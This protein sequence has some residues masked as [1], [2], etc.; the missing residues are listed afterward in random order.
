M[1]NMIETILQ[2]ISPEAR[3]ALAAYFGETPDS[4]D[5]ALVSIIPTLLAAMVSRSEHG[6]LES[7][8]ALVRTSLEHD[9]ALDDLSAALSDPGRRSR[10]LA[11]GG[12]FVSALLGGQLGPVSAALTGRSGV[13]GDTI[14]GLLQLGG[15]LVTGGVGKML[16]HHQPTSQELSTLLKSERADIFARLPSGISSLLAPLSGAATPATAA[17][18]REEIFGP[19]V[20]LQPA[21]DADEAVR[22]A[23]DTCYGLSAAVLGGNA[24]RALTVAQRLEAG[25]IQVNDSTMA[26]EIGLPNGGVKNSGWGYTGPAGMHDFTEIRQTSV[27]QAIGAYPVPRP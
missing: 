8:A 22:I 12:S 16:G 1:P 27:Q 11:N 20:L 3:S 5:R 21:T 15:S 9:N 7:V 10:L 4:T 14:R 6:G 18:A 23:N 13:K 19:V 25:M 17:A 24:D 2:S 26:G